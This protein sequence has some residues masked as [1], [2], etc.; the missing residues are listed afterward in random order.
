MV[1]TW[2]YKNVSEAEATKAARQKQQFEFGLEK[3]KASWHFQASSR[4]ILRK[5]SIGSKK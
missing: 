4:R 2:R 1:A 3:T 5:D